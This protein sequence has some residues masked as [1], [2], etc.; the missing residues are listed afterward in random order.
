M[1]VR[2]FEEKRTTAETQVAV[3]LVVDGSGQ[4][5]IATGIPFFDH[6]LTQ[7]AKH[8]G[9]DLTLTPK[10]DVSLWGN[11]PNGVNDGIFDCGGGSING[12]YGI[13]R[14]KAKGTVRIGAETMNVRGI[15]GVLV[16]V[17]LVTFG[18]DWLAAQ[19]AGGPGQGRG[20]RG[21]GAVQRDLLYAAVPGRT[22]DIGVGGIGILVFDAARNFRFRAIL[23]S[24]ARR[25]T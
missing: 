6:M 15:V 18:S 7:L 16:A 25:R 21:A 1:T 20:G 5:E 2:R 22:N 9:F 14:L 17:G 13:T 4:I 3:D 24:A 23:R 8:G 10:R 12:Y 11:N 19:R